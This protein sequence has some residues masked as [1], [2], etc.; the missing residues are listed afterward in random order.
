MLSV[1]VMTESIQFVIFL[2]TVSKGGETSVWDEDSGATNG[3]HWWSQTENYGK[4]SL[5]SLPHIPLLEACSVLTWDQLCVCVRV[6]M[7]ACIHVLVSVC[8]CVYVCVRTHAI[9]LSN[10]T[11]NL[12]SPQHPFLVQIHYFITPYCNISDI[13]SKLYSQ[14][15]YILL[16]LWL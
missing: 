8:V 2:Y 14:C 7:H 6:C 4:C 11:P 9:L 5:P 12:P 15:V 13:I 10:L 1:W 3:G 16:L